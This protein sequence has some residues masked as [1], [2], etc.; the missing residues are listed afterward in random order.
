[1][2]HGLSPERSA[3]LVSL[4]T[5]THDEASHHAECLVCNLDSNIEGRNDC[6]RLRTGMQNLHSYR[7]REF[8][9]Q[10]VAFA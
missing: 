4:Q 1:M 8:G 3:L 6:S 10:Q 7:G 9:L 5:L 2:I